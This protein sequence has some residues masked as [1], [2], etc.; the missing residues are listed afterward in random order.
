MD[1]LLFLILIS[2]PDNFSFSLF[3]FSPQQEQLNLLCLWPVTKWN[4]S[5]GAFFTQP[6]F[7]SLESQVWKRPMP[8]S[9]CLSAL[10]TLWLSWAMSQFSSSSRPRRPSESPC[11]TFWPSFQ[12]SIWPF[13][14]PP[15]PGCWVSSGLMYM[16]LTWSLC[17]PD[18]SDPRPHW[19]GGW[20]IL[21]M[22]FDRYVAICAPLH[23]TTILTSR[24][25]V[26]IS[27]CIVIRPVLLRPV[28]LTFPT[29]YLIYLLPL[30]QAQIRAHSYCEHM[31]IAKLSYENRQ[32][33]SRLW[34]TLRQK[35]KKKRKKETLLPH[36]AEWPQNQHWCWVWICS[37]LV[38][39]THPYL[40]THWEPSI[41]NSLRLLQWLSL[42]GIWQ[43]RLGRLWPFAHL[44]PGSLLMEIG[45]GA[46]LGPS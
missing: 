43:V 42:T 20:G 8:G 37:T 29:I 40:V 5:T 44:P 22:A 25:L 45:R 6:H 13:P 1:V 12:Q 30:C 28:L 34:C 33:G 32:G 46:Q 39:T 18:V 16:R 9:P 24:V 10:F 4:T 35:Q 41:S 31:G 7:S 21:A 19:H 36:V 14:P 17:G 15:C 38:N 26:G 3:C 2:S 27:L 11:S 23:Y